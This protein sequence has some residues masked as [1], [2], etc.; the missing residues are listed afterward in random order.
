M[1]G[2]DFEY[3]P[4]NQMNEIKKNED[5]NSGESGILCRFNCLRVLKDLNSRRKIHFI[6][7]NFYK[8]NIYEIRN[9]IFDLAKIVNYL[10]SIL[11]EGEEISIKLCYDNNK[12]FVHEIRVISEM[13]PFDLHIQDNVE[14]ETV[15]KKYCVDSV[16]TIYNE[17]LNKD[18]TINVIFDIGIKN[19][20]E[21]GFYK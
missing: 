1:N 2:E 14:Y 16:K 21:E 10:F 13:N 19:L 20:Y 8:E 6:N 18:Y 3:L 5:F 9:D 11:D 15:F 17:I 7:F 4:S 12:R